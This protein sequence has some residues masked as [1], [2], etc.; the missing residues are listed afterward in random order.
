MMMMFEIIAEDVL[1]SDIGYPRS[2]PSPNADVSLLPCRLKNMLWS[3]KLAE[4]RMLLCPIWSCSRGT[5]FKYRCT[6]SD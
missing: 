3:S 6:W 2:A 1:A 5:T 4:V